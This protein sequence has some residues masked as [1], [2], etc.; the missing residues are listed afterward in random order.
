[1]TTS[2]PGRIG[3]SHPDRWLAMLRIVVG[4]YFVKALWTKLSI[5]L[6]GGFF[7]LPIVSERWIGVMP[8]L[9]EKQAAGNPI[10]FYK[11]FLEEVVLPNARLFAQLTAWGE[12]LVGIG[13][14]LGLLN[15][16]AAL[17]GLLLS[18]SYGLAT[19]WMTPNQFGFHLVLVTV[20]LAFFMTRAGRGWGLDAWLAWRFP[21]SWVTKRPWS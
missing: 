15:G 1:M 8:T 14:T 6:V 13:L 5:T 19:Q 17:V 11:A 18:I 10:L 21:D 16:F 9:V 7:P 4:L 20:M 3:M 2:S 12:V